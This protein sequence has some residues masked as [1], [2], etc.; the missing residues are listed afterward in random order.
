MAEPAPAAAM[1]GVASTPWMTQVE[2]PTPPRLAPLMAGAASASS[3]AAPSELEQATA[4][5]PAMAETETPAQQETPVES[6]PVAPAAPLAPTTWAE[7]A[8]QSVATAAMASSLTPLPAP[9]ASH[10]EA[11]TDTTPPAEATS[12]PATRPWWMPI[13]EPFPAPEPP[14]AG[15]A[16]AVTDTVPLDVALPNETVTTSDNGVD[17]GPPTTD[18]APPGT[19][20][21]AQMSRVQP[22]AAQTDDEDVRFFPRPRPDHHDA[23]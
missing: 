7:S 14:A 2:T 21:Q 22:E 13:D 5:T 8:E 1:S 19:P 17:A 6:V 12:T 23:T 4:A 9:D 20:A 11:T 10:A 15:S 18:E 16:A 3:T